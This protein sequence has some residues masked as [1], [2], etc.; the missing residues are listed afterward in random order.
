MHVLEA[1]A[2][3]YEV[4][5]TVVLDGVDLEV[6]EGEK[7]AVVGPSG[8]GKTTLLA[9]LGGLARPT[10]GQVLID[11]EPLDGLAGPGRG[12]A[13]VLQGYGL[14]SLLTAAE[15][16]EIAVRAI[17]AS[18]S[19]AKH[20]AAGA[21]EAVGL[22][23]HA[24]QLVEELSG[25]Q[26]QRVAVARALAQRPR[27]LLAD[28]PTAELDAKMRSLVLARMLEVVAAGSALVLAT[29]DLDVAARCDRVLDLKAAG[30]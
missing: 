21:L 24:D 15:N 29:H 14:V 26:Q 10:R 28:E 6:D 8:S 11:G 17:G 23:A 1:S 7:L 16:V 20:E 12:V 9:L 22:A 5:G 30:G 19:Q 13:V 27:I 2:L 3:R 4:G 18:P 25:G